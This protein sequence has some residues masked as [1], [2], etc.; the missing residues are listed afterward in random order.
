MMNCYT[1]SIKYISK[2]KSLIS[3]LVKGF[4]VA[5]SL[6]LAAKS[7]ISAAVSGR[8]IK[9]T[10]K[11][12]IHIAI[13]SLKQVRKNSVFASLIRF[14]FLSKAVML[15]LIFLLGVPGIVSAQTVLVSPTGDGGFETGA[16]F[17]LNGWTV[18]N[19]VANY[20]VVGGTTKNSGTSAAY[21]SNTGTGN[22]YTISSSSTSHFYRD[23][24]VPAGESNI[25]LSFYLQGS[26]EVDWD[27]LLVY[28]AP[29]SVTPIAG[30]PASSSITLA[31]ASL[32][33]TQTALIPSFTLQTITLPASLSGTTFRLIFTWQNDDVYG[34]P[35]PA[36]IDNI[37]VISAS[38]A[39]FSSSGIFTVPA[40][41]ASMQ[42]EAWG[43]GG[44][45]GARISNGN[46]G[47]GG[48]GAYSRSA[49]AVVPG[50]T[51]SFSVGAGSTSTSAG[52]DSYFVNTST[53]LA[54]GGASV[55]DN[56][57]TGAAGGAAGSG[58]GNF[59]K[60]GG[61]GDNGAG[62]YGGGGGSSAGTALNGVAATNATGAIAPLGGGNGGNGRSGSQGNGLAGSIP[63]GGGG[64]AYKTSSST[65]TGGAGGAGQVI[66]SWITVSATSIETCIGANT[67]TATA[68][69]GTS[70][71]YSLDGTNYQASPI[72]TGLDAGSYTVYA[73]DV[74]GCVSFT[75]VTVPV[76]SIAASTDDQNAVAVDS[77]IGHVY[78]GTNF[79]TYYGHYTEPETFIENFG[80]GA[81]CFPIISNSTS[82]SINT[83]TF[84][85]KYRMNST[86]RGLY[87]ADLGWDDGTRLTVDGSIVYD[88]W[89]KSVWPPSRPG[90]LMSLNGTSKLLYEY[91]GGGTANGVMFQN[92]MKLINN[93]LAANTT[94][95]ILLGS[96]GAVISGDVYGALPSGVSLSG[97]GYQWT[98]STTPGG[99]RTNIAGATGAVF[100]PNTTVAPLN[101]PGTYYLYR[102]AILSSANNIA[103]NPYVAT[104]ESNVATITVAAP[105]ISTSVSALNGFSYSV[106]HGPSAEQSLT[107]VGI[108]LVG[109][110]AVTPSTNFEVSVL[111]GGV[112]QSTP[113]VLTAVG[114]VVNTTVYVRL[115]QGLVAGSYGPET[116]VIASGSYSNNVTC[117]GDVVPAITAGGGGSYC[118]GTTIN[119]TSSGVNLAN[120]YWEGPNGFYSTDPNPIISSA[121]TAMSGTYTVKGN[122]V[123]LGNLVVNGNFESGNTGFA[124]SYTL[125]SGASD[126]LWNPGIYAVI[127]D[128]HSQHSNF[129]ILGDHTTGSG[130]QFVAN[131]AGTP[132]KI[133]E[134]A[135]LIT[136]SPN[137]NYQFRYWV[138]TVDP[139]D[140]N[141]S[142][143]QL[144]INGTPA[145]PICTASAVQG[146][147]TQFV[148]NWNS[149]SSTTADLILMS[150][151]TVGSGNDFAI[152]DIVFQPVYTSSASVNVSVIATSSPASVSIVA[153][154][155]NSVNSGT[156]V[157]FTA[158]PTSGG[159]AP[160]YQ[161]QVN[162]INVGTNNPTYTYIPTDGNTV[163]CTMTSN[164]GCLVGSGTV[165]SNTITMAVNNPPN[166][167][168]GAYGTDWGTAG[169]WTAGY[170]PGIGD[171]IVFSTTSTSGDAQNNLI[172]DADRTVGNLT[173]L[174]SK[175]LIIPPA[176][177]LT[178]NGAIIT[179]GNA[180]KIYIQA[181]P[182]GTQQNGSLIFHNDVSSPVYASVEMHSK[183]TRDPSGVYDPVT[184]KTY[185]YSWQY[186]GIPLRSVVAD[187]A[188]YGSYVRRND[189]A[190]TNTLGKWIPLANSD[191]L[192]SFTGYE[193][194]QDAP[195][196]FVFQGALEN[197]DKSIVLPYTST[198]YDP[199]Q[200]ILANPYTAAIDVRQLVFGANTEKTVYLYNTGS[201]GQWADKNGE[202]TNDANTTIP[203]QYIAIPQRVAASIGL[204]NDIPSMSGFLVK[205]MGEGGGSLTINYNSVITKN[206]NPQR[207]PQRA[208]ASDKVYMQ[209]TLKGKRYGDR[210]WL[211]DE[212]GTT[213]DFDN[214]W[215]GY[216]LFGAV[217]TPKLFAMENDANYQISTSGDINNTYLGFQAGVDL[218]DTLTFKSENIGTR[219]S[220][221]Y[222]VDLV[223]NK[224]I[225]IAKSGTQYTFKA[226]AT[227]APIKRFKIVTLPI[228]ENPANSAP[229]L[230]VFN[231]NNIV[232]VDNSS[233]QKGDLYFYDIMGRYLKKE[234]FVPNAVSVFPLFSVPGAYIV[235]TVTSTEEVS[236]KI[237]IK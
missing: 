71:T 146:S 173:N 199:G 193:I 46:G 195:T 62:T 112:F 205:A 35:P 52:G 53:L 67:I 51:Y 26:G 15:A 215:D 150:E 188:F 225:D 149:G 58:V 108:G 140:S 151:N 145:G 121:T 200:T 45:G 206:V 19:A 82:R 63:G 117:R 88:D 176:K 122:F 118:A 9:N 128:P 57:A 2:V 152:D 34:A 131:G 87:V 155:G 75:S 154:P 228:D 135:T 14:D 190:S 59:K 109:N 142:Q 105:G 234:P 115:K 96:S 5:V 16:T 21:I 22:A 73:K 54:K 12:V 182:D 235:K 209:I 8:L 91:Y 65:K 42:V 202:T 1:R 129:C 84:S 144:L 222:L 38:N 36:A 13:C 116:M 141:P 221:I 196:T 78:D 230:K 99:A 159:T 97:T 231:D 102:N 229:R 70:Y 130:L 101:T 179:N 103:P 203:G 160:I 156:S 74:S 169:N 79:D 148:Y 68:S 56:V 43:G 31:G 107:V 218:E 111:S 86:K 48:G 134:P 177:C 201:F 162:G 94:Q 64:G 137:T 210:V 171:D 11:L 132:Q 114:G 153:S 197:G 37:S 232:F 85:I 226:E 211:I 161:W 55:A 126:G 236:K 23:I 29:T 47:G 120:Q 157:T 127:A 227:P 50:N 185:Y 92:F 110:M 24:T 172:L 138:Q 33:Y 175:Q 166:Y 44:K 147:W 123:P 83:Q 10:E 104:N 178:A 180:N 217:G 189:E 17:S 167:W 113:L 100:T 220:R 207:A 6:E 39:T 136:V 124:T 168:K 158:T 186:F 30:T 191:V 183:A 219:Y 198:A 208:Q 216:K 4:F 237:I 61:K 194:T 213:H 204:P 223:E 163:T 3:I 119:L 106:G 60:S 7:V 184:N 125:S 77:W 76:T 81:N 139:G 90:V 18:V 98:Y 192:S 165:T 174:S 224:V 89:V 66:I 32:V 214:G 164:S 72:F 40:G 93:I 133:W 187:P 27:R 170:V 95:T 181:W 143:T 212:P 41:V 25:T 28:T 49:L 69:G 233:N 20:W 80:S